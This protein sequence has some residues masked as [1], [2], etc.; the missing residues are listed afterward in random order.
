MRSIG[1]GMT[2]GKMLCGMMNLPAPLT[3]HKNYSQILTSTSEKI[4]NESMAKAVCES[5]QLNKNSRDLCVAID[6]TWQKRGHKSLNG[7]VSTTSA[8]NYKV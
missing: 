4:A 2:A 6:G 7:V 5:V 3:R 1:K 8:D